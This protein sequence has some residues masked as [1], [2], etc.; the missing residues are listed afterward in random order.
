MKNYSY[1]QYQYTFKSPL[2]FH[3]FLSDLRGILDTFL[4][5]SLLPVFELL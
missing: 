4:Q 2:F 1:N 3:S 5:N